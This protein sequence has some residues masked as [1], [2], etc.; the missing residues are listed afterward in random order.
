MIDI[1]K[2]VVRKI[3]DP[4]EGLL[5]SLD[6]NP[7]TLEEWLDFFNDNIG[8]INIYLKPSEKL[9]KIQFGEIIPNNSPY[10]E[11]YDRRSPLHFLTKFIIYKKEVHKRLILNFSSFKKLIR[12]LNITD[13]KIQYDVQEFFKK[14]NPDTFWLNLKISDE[15]QIELFKKNDIGIVIEAREKALLTNMIKNLSSNNISFKSIE[16]KNVSNASQYVLVLNSDI[17]VKLFLKACEDSGKDEYELNV[18][19]YLSSDKKDN[20]ADLFGKLSL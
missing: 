3:T 2:D 11:I 7:E 10:I 18:Y 4:K 20:L 13:K 6:S 12:M 8:W 9:N 14:T 15:K 16:E 19:E 17:L 5:S 1:I